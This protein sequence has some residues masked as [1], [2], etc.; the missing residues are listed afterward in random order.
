MVLADQIY[1]LLLVQL[2][3]FFNTW[4]KMDKD[5]HLII[6]DIDL[7]NQIICYTFASIIQTTKYFLI[8]NSMVEYRFWGLG[9]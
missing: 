6:I 3:H 2:Y 1:L 7:H 4:T 5:S 9:P 8:I